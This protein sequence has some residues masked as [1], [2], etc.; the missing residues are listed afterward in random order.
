MCSLQP[1]LVVVDIDGT[2]IAT[3]SRSDMPSIRPSFVLRSSQRGVP[4][5][6]R[7]G[8]L[9]LLTWAVV[10]PGVRLG[11]FTASDRDYAE[12]VMTLLLASLDPSQDL[13][14]LACFLTSDDCER[15]WRGTC[16]T[17]KDLT[18]ACSAVGIPLMRT[19]IIDDKAA[20]TCCRNRANAIGVKPWRG[21]LHN[22]SRR[23]ELAHVLDIC[24]ELANS[25]EDVSLLGLDS[26]GSDV[27]CWREH[28][29]HHRLRHPSGQANHSLADPADTQDDSREARH[30]PVG[31]C[32]ESAHASLNSSAGR[33]VNIQESPEVAEDA[34]DFA[35]HA[36]GT[37][38]IYAVDLR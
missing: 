20:E 4:I 30:S 5:W 12:E 24:M 32:V 16:E 22:K 1:L 14:A 3:P 33:I 25:A 28:I 15:R 35:G 10:D 21:E 27:A 38:G 26:L 2:L 13:S 34:S 17:T 23:G 11:V 19:L 29:S 9:E 37:N 31:C 6:V 8:A 7:P 36:E 18:R